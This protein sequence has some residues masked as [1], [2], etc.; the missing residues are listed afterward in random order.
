M[1]LLFCDS[2]DHYTAAGQKY[3]SANN[4]TIGAFG[5]HSTNGARLSSTAGQPE[6]RKTL[7]SSYSTL[8]AGFALSPQDSATLRPV[9]RFATGTT[10][11][12]SLWRNASNQL[13]VRR[14]NSTATLGNSGANVFPG[15]SYNYIEI[16]VTF[17]ATTG[18]VEVRSNGVA[19][20]S[21][22]NVNTA[23]SGTTADSAGLG[24][25]GS[26]ANSGCDFDDFYVCDTSGS[27]NNNFLGD[28]RVEALLPTGAG[29]SAQFTP[30]A[31]SNY[32]NVDETAPNDDT[33]YN[34]SSTAGQIDLFAFGNL[35]ATSGSV[36]G[37]QY[38]VRARKDD[39]GTRTVRPKV[40][41]SS[42][43]YDGTSVNVTSAYAYIREVA[44]VSPATASAW[45]ISEINGAEFGYEL[46][47]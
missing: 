38:L 18:S 30:S 36:L 9:F 45:T 20:I 8:V 27:T 28:V 4:F 43:N 13:E 31:G 7:P 23:A 34:S 22:T 17:H 24:I 46:V 25:S 16:K 2:F 14:G 6:L 35:T 11:Q 15:G 42:T 3:E 1:A 5:R 32:Q 26:G 40:R 33:D 19:I 44:E 41:I 10:T 29:N 47:A 37:A 39:A 12:V 21:L